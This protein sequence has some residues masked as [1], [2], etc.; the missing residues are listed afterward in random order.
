VVNSSPTNRELVEKLLAAYMSGDEDVLR[1]AVAPDSEVH[2]H[3]DIVNAG[4]YYGFEGFR[5]WARDWEEAWEEVSYELGEL[6]EVS[7][8]FLVAPVHVTGRG[9]GSGIEIDS[10]FGWL[11]G[12]R[13]G[14]VVQFHVYATVEEAVETA[15]R[16]TGE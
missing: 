15:R 16:L 4:T 1:A 14:Q 6:I 3:P 8:S 10:V 9:A 11:Y 13:D 5:Q 12:F 2:G 7:D